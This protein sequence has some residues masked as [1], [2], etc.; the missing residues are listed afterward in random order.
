MTPAQ[1]AV[2]RIDVMREAFSW[3][4]TPFHDKAGV[5]GVGVDCAFFPYHVYRSA[6]LIPAFE[7]PDYS[8]QFLLHSK[9]ERYLAVVEQFAVR[10][11]RTPLPGDFL[12]YWFG[13]CHSHGAIAAD[14][15]R[16]IHARKPVGVTFDDALDSQLLLKLDRGSAAGAGRPVGDPRPMRVYSLK[17]W[18]NVA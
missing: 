12:M 10:V 9:E 6:G 3:Q 5:K 7:I 2:Q 18:E 14:W 4:R 16:I 17:T 13:R 15:P 11:D 8:P 1:V